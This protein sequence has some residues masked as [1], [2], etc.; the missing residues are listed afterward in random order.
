MPKSTKLLVEI[1]QQK[2]KAKRNCSGRRALPP[3]LP[4]IEHLHEPKSCTCQQ[5]GQKLVKIRD[6]VSEQLD[7][8]PVRFIV[9]RHI[10]PQYACRQCKQITAAA[11]RPAIIHGGIATASLLAWVATQKYLDHLPLYRITV[12]SRRHG[13]ELPRSTL[14]QWISYIGMALQPLNDRLCELLRQRQ[15]LHADESPVAQLAPGQG[16]TKQSYLWAYRSCD[17]ED[18]P[19]I[20]VFDYQPGRNGSYAQEFLKGWTGYLMADGYAGYKTLF[21]N[22][23]IELACLAHIRR[24]FKDIYLAN[25]NELAAD[26]LMR[27]GELY[28]IEQR[29]QGLT[30]NARQ[31]L[32][33]AE[34][35]PK[36]DALHTW[37]IEARPAVAEGSPMRRAIDYGLRRWS[38]LERYAASG[39]LPIDNNPAENSI[40]PNALGRKN[41]LFTG[42]EQAGKRAAVIQS[43]FATAKLNGVEPYSWLKDTLEKLPNW[44]NSRLD[45]L[46]PLRRLA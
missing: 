45:E 25:Q 38:A 16:K 42:T 37:L 5:C 23:V 1:E 35:K 19:P 20:V 4:R 28:E 10:R 33:L 22:G 31:S 2:E 14:A 41:W 17:L 32:R 29:G 24:K 21:A 18:G 27:I 13:V 34:A 3:A 40:R 9:H 15:V 43:M 30:A 7:V 26:V 12:I 39:M 44:P 36:L 11:A 6:D 8:E 46:L